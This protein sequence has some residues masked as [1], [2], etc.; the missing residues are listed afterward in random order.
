MPLKLKPP[1]LPSQPPPEAPPSATSAKRKLTLTFGGASH[2]T[3]SLADTPA[4]VTTAKKSKA[5]KKP[6]VE[7][8]VRASKPTPKKR[9]FDASSLADEDDES[10]AN[11]L[12]TVKRLKLVA[13]PKSPADDEFKKIKHVRLK[14]KGRVPDRPI[15]VG[16]DSGS[17]DVEQDPA[18]EEEFILRMEPGEDCEYIRQAIA[19]R[20]WG[21]SSEGGAD[22]RMHF[23]QTDG[24]RAVVSVQKR[25]Y[26]ACLVDLPCI[27]EGM[28]SWDKK[29][30]FKT[31]DICQMLLVLGRVKQESEAM[32]YELPEGVDPQTFQYAHGLTPPMQYARQR[33][34][35]KRLSNRAIEAVEEEVER[36]LQEDQDCVD[37][38]GTV[39]YEECDANGQ[40]QADR[41]QAAREQ[42]EDL[43]EYGDDNAE[44]EEDAEGED[45][46]DVANNYE[47]I[48]EDE[49]EEEEDIAAA[50]GELMEKDN[51]GD[52][53]PSQSQMA[54]METPD[55]AAAAET[56][57][58]QSFMSSPSSPA[59][60]PAKVASVAD[61]G[62]D[63]SASDSGDEPEELDEAELEKQQERD[64]QLAEIND[65]KAMI[66]T[67]E[68]RASTQSNPLLRTKL[69]ATAKG[70]KRDLEVKMA[71]L[72]VEEDA[73]EG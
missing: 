1:A 47:P 49:G 39:L 72:G 63:D 33:R 18:L 46:E 20:R 40:T 35:R 62:D 36:L 41:D 66:K 53:S 8:P 43:E 3:P 73:D 64:K 10:K 71:A 5:P 58:Q 2:P 34:F 12:A 38:G 13:K 14:F 27:V 70:L 9:E 55:S 31:A 4:S 32:D 59:A 51:D 16:Y 52:A 7:K 48:E 69:L 42:A 61:S 29:A 28:K 21:P 68:E 44:G 6:K 25:L 26:A 15:G 24:R 54:P 11:G 30:W 45:E 23:L 56:P 60:T 22:V 50:L 57:L 65:M 67:Q 19:E 17:S 37:N